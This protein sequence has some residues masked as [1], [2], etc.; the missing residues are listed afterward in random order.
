MRASLRAL[1]EGLIDYAGLFPPAKLPLP[2][3]LANYQRYRAGPEAWMLGRFIC[4]A[5]RLGE[6]PATVELPCSA[7]ARGSDDV[8]TFLTG[9]DADLKDIEA[10]HL[11][12]DVLEVRPPPAG[13]L[14]DVRALTDLIGQSLARSEATRCMLFVEAPVSDFT[15]MSRVVGCLHGKRREGRPVGFKLRAGG[16]EASAFP[17]TAQVA[18]A[19]RVCAG[20]EVPMKATAGLHHPLPRYYPGVGTRMHGFVNLFVAGVLAHAR[21]IGVDRIAELLDDADP[22]SFVFIDD[23]LRWRD[24]AATT[25]EVREAR[26]TAVLSFGSCSFDEPR[27]DLRALGWM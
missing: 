10:S 7:L 19:L 22:A 15:F 16:L 14:G 17:T 2:E 6:I 1:L 9:I 20:W 23:E 5:S 13:V 11:Q 27:D 25:A 8:P 26:R 24:V 4:P 18:W 12:V 21:G 3:A